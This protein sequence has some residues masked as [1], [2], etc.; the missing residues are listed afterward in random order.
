MR[1]DQSNL[2]FQTFFEEFRYDI[3]LKIKQSDKYLIGLET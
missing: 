3:I 1:Y 2:N